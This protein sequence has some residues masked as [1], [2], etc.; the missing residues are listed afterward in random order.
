[1]GAQENVQVIKD[2]YAAFARGDMAALMALFADDIEWVIPGEG[3]PLAGTYRG[4]AGVTQ[5]FQQLTSVSEILSFE[6]L[7]FIGEGDRV[8]VVGRERARV[9]NTNRTVET[10]WIM[11]WTVR[12]GKVTN[13]REYT[14]TLAWARAHEIAASAAA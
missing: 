13:F 10:N 9:K 7:E 5:F 8:V 1:M 14:D 4:H 11:T 6:P 12:N 2:G 3:L